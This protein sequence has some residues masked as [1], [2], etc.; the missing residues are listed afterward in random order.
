MIKKRLL[1][2]IALA[3]V[4]TATVTAQSPVS[5]FMQ[6]KGKGNIV[7]SYGMEK[8]SK[9]FLVPK[10]IDGVPVFNEVEISS[11]SVYATYGLTDELDLVVSLP[12]VSATGNASE[13]VLTNLNFEN[14]RIGV[15]DISIF[16][17]LNP[18]NYNV[19]SSKLSFIGA[20]GYKAPVGDYRADE[21]LQSIIAIG[22]R[23]KT[24][25]LI[26]IAM[27][28]TKSGIFTTGQFGGLMNINSLPDGYMSEIKLGYA[29]S[30]IYG[31][32]FLANQTS[33]TGVDI[34]GNGFQGF[35]PATKVD[36]TRI[37]LN[38]YAPV[39][40]NIGLAAGANAYI[41]GRNLG[42][43]TGFYGALVYKF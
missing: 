18:F 21:G 37:G 35:F 17:K 3:I 39:Y 22:N 28:K 14:K 20:L 15:Q 25:S 42:K 16:L 36:L 31:D 40:K 7:M 26:G 23:A 24:V 27:F 4:T 8:Y 2:V 10:E 33:V 11:A 38:L 43:S 1:S 30:K 5:G 41:A 6:G 32:V 12:Y 29:A 34:L 13:A 9:V 19:G